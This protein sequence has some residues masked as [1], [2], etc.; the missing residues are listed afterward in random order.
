MNIIQIG[1]NDCADHVFEYVSKHRDEVSA[2]MVV[3]A[4][5]GCVATAKQKYGFLGSRL[6]PVNCAVG[7][8]NGLTEF[9]FP[10]GEDMSAH[11]SMSADHLRNH[12]HNRLQ[13]IVVPCL[14]LN[15]LV[16]AFSR[17]VDRLYID[18][19]GS[20][21]DVLLSFAL[22]Q[23]K[24]KFLEYEFLHSDGTFHQ[25]DKHQQLLRLLQECG[26]SYRQSE[27]SAY[28]IEAQLAPWELVG[29]K[30]AADEPK[31]TS[32]LDVIIPGEIKDDSFYDALKTL[33]TLPEVKTILEIGSSA[34]GG[35]TEAF[36]SGLKDRS[37]PASLY[38]MEVSATRFAQLRDTYKAYNF[39]H[40]FNVSSVPLGEFP[41]HQ[42]VGEFWDTVQSGLRAYPKET[43]LGWLDADLDYV[44]S[45]GF[46][47]NGISLIKAEREIKD[48]DV[49]LIDGSEFTGEAELRHVHGAR[50]IALDD[51]NTH[52][53]WKNYFQLKSDPGYEL[54]CE[55]RSVRN[56]FC[57]FK[58]VEAQK[59]LPV[60]FFTIVLNGMPFI[61]H[62][63]E[64]MQD[65][66]FDWHW[67]IVEGV[68]DLKH[69]TAWSVG[70]GGA[71]TEDLHILG[72]SRD[73]TSEY[74]DELAA[75]YPERV[76]IYRK[77]IGT[78]WEGKLEMVNAPLARI[79]SECLLWEIDADE[80]WTAE[81]I[82]TARNLFLADNSL[83][84][85]FYWCKFFVGREIAV[86]TRN[87]Y[88]Q[89]PGLEWLRTWRF[90]PSCR[91][92]AH[93]P[94]RLAVLQPDGGWADQG[95]IKPL[96]H[97]ETEAAGLVFH[98]Y[99]Y[100]TQAQLSFKEVYYGYQNAVEGWKRLQSNENF[101][102]PL[103]DYFPWVHDETQVDKMD[104]LGIS[105]L[106][107]TARLLESE[108]HTGASTEDIIVDAVFFQ[109]YKTGIARVW[110]SLLSRWAETEFGKRL[111]ILDRAG[112]AP[113]IPGLKY[114]E[115]PAHDYAN[116]GG[117]QE[118][119]QK[120]CD[121]KAA[122]LFVSSY[123][124]TPVS[125]PSI[126]L[127]HD[128]IP[129]ILDADLNHP[130]WMEKVHAIK[131]ASAYVCVSKNTANDLARFHPEISPEKI[132]VAYNGVAFQQP[133]TDRV[134]AFQSRHGIEK[135]YFLISGG[136]SSYKNSIQFFNAFAQF[137]GKRGNFDIVCT[138]PGESLEP[139]FAALS[140]NASIHL[141]DL[142]D[143]ELECAYGG[144]IALVYPS[145][146]EG[147]GMPIIEAMAC[148]CPVITCPNGPLPEVAGEAALYVPSHD[149]DE[150]FR[151]LEVIQKPDVRK[152]LITKGQ[153]RA[154][155]FSWD[156]MANEVAAVMTA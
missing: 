150:M 4:L 125:T 131:R 53:N 2:F 121:W 136:R 57:I 17:P 85:A 37:D 80:L 63:I 99:A 88:S 104:R 118:L 25:G 107:G 75:K 156:R 78:H 110:K 30:P 33:A 52:K 130:M 15:V 40:C 13:S 140:G 68:A 148:G 41:S 115:F 24:P 60:H 124:T 113:R 76:S 54:I 86:S 46:D 101:P 35:S 126:L 139:E 89:N 119:I 142:P 100:A 26:Y 95:T 153:D 58:R 143:E 47:A 79:R 84:A 31:S 29:A 74:L 67:H 133:T 149:V 93:E 71:V 112:S 72:R 20:D 132:T 5:H 105:H 144:A 114:M 43:V 155:M 122:R 137:N 48:F 1:C 145:L 62:H 51:I 61:R 146:Y 87:C 123:Y 66:P 128:M 12:L 27:S 28:N 90:Y 103:K 64:M 14:S 21:V 109:Y 38:C 22:G 65:L 134:S 96:R 138:G 154:A 59:K 6:I 94:P 70:N 49:V 10:Q 18:L 42:A 32:V 92:A 81:K 152:V 147:F 9:Y 50:Y 97:A 44:K 98:H 117:D 36:V 141:L 55:D 3:D 77:P 56:G 111:L 91:W 135:P 127:V 19:E 34:G 106:P 129:E 102:C 7:T 82:A 23:F 116:T 69:D 120:V 45:H 16:A 108:P 151:A 11:A 8:M 73:G 83:T 39:V